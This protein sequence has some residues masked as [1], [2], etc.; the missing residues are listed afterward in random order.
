[1]NLAPGRFP[2]LNSAHA[3]LPKLVLNCRTVS[4]TKAPENGGV[5]RMGAMWP[6]PSAK[7]G[8]VLRLSLD[9]TCVQVRG[10]N[11]L[12]TQNENRA[13]NSMVVIC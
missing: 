4:E 2:C 6:R 7:I 10:L 12:K 1:M 3:R 11:R 9:L 13:Q 5:G 8:P